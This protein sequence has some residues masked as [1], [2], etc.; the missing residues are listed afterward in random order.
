MAESTP[1]QL[2]VFVSEPECETGYFQSTGH[3]SVSLYSNYNEV[4]REEVN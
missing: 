1:E 3:C 4:N 2:T